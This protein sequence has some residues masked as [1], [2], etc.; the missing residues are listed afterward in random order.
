MGVCPRKLLH[1]HVDNPRIILDGGG[2]LGLQGAY[3][4][5]VIA[6]DTH[7]RPGGKIVIVKCVGFCQKIDMHL[8]RMISAYAVYHGSVRT[9]VIIDG[10]EYC[11]WVLINVTHDS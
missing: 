3:F 7:G 9:T 5:L 6:C 1:D 8:A 10:T 11:Y 4:V 2:A